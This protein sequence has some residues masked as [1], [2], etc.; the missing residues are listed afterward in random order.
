MGMIGTERTREC[1]SENVGDA[2][3]CSVVKLAWANAVG[4][5]PTKFK[6]S[7]ASALAAGR[8]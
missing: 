4:A 3:R 7:A 8:R 5:F 2:W 6:V 1:C